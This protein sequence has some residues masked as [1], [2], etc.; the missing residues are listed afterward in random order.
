MSSDTARPRQQPL[1]P[2][3][4]VG[5]FLTL[6][7][8]LIG[9]SVVNRYASIVIEM[10]NDSPAI[11]VKTP[12]GSFPLV[13]SR[14]RLSSLTDVIYPGSV[15][16]DQLDV[17]WY[18]G[19]SQQETKVGQLT[20][21]RFRTTEQRVKLYEWYQSKLGPNFKVCSSWPCSHAFQDYGWDTAVSENWS[22]VMG[23]QEESPGRARGVI[24]AD[25]DSKVLI[26]LYEFQTAKRNGTGP[27]EP[28]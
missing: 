13:R 6:A 15:L 4:C 11:A 21:L 9:I 14:D 1:W 8:V 25:N 24:L 27:I 2:V 26:S 28:R 17:N 10:G 23:F 3:Y 12:L 19:S 22:S 7:A 18:R 5:T 20:V 16:K